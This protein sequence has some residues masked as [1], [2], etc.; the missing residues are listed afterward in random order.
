M[1][2]LPWMFRR[3]KRLAPEEMARPYRLK[4]REHLMRNDLARAVAYLARA[5]EVAPDHLPLYLERAQILQYGMDDCCAALRDYR[6]VLRILE[7]TPDPTIEAEC[8]RGIRDMMARE[9]ATV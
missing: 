9:E 1:R 8:R 7:A 6:H 4:A 2:L 5:L 3:E